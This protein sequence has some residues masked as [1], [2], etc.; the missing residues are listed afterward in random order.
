MLAHSTA[1]AFLLPSS[2]GRRKSCVIVLCYCVME[3]RTK[4]RIQNLDLQSSPMFVVLSME[5]T[6]HCPAETR[7]TLC[8]PAPPRTGQVWDTSLHF[9]LHLTAR[10]FIFIVFIYGFQ[11]GPLHRPDTLLSS[12][13]E[14]VERWPPA[15]L[16][17]VNRRSGHCRGWSV[18]PAAHNP[19]M[20]YSTPVSHII[21]TNHRSLGSLFSHFSTPYSL[22][23]KKWSVW[24]KIILH[25]SLID[26]SEC[27][28]QLHMNFKTF[29]ATRCLQVSPG[30][31]PR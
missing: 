28:Y 9:S 26:W 10:D 20:D 8:G 14:Q 31:D 5:R 6:L 24:R 15:P 25:W 27:N 22:S 29:K 21:P 17:Q 12:Q 23:E 3:V 13:A 11:Q 2:R 18:W 16:I 1:T 19:P 7:E 4:I 30:G